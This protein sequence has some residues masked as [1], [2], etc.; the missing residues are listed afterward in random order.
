MAHTEWLPLPGTLP[1][2]LRK[3][4]LP[5]L[6]SVIANGTTKTPTP[7]PALSVSSAPT[8]TQTPA[9]RPTSVTGNFAATVATGYREVFGGVGLP[10]TSTQ[11]QMLAD[12]G[13]TMVRWAYNI[14]WADSINQVVPATSNSAYEAAMSAAALPAAHAI[15]TLG[16]GA[17][18]RRPKRCFRKPMYRDSTT[19]TIMGDT[20]PWN[21]VNGTITGHADRLDGL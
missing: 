17:M 15:P 7:T 6:R 14:Y 11:E 1:A 9:H 2:W 16:P 10:F 12:N 18:T 8:P 19:M 3:A 5:T 20:T 4:S 21:S 13:D